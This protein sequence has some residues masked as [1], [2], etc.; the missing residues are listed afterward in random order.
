MTTITISGLP[1]TGKTTVAKLLENRLGLRYVYSGE[2]F[3]NMAKKY[4][5]SLEEFG[6]YCE[7]HREIDEDL[8]RYQLG[9]LRQGSVIVEG[10]ISG[11]LA[12]QNHIP[13]VKVLLEAD[14]AI[15]AGRIVKR[16]AGDLEKRKKEILK[17][18]KSEATRYKK[19]YG[20][21]VADTS[22]YDVI[23]DAGDKTPDE[24]MEIIVKHLGE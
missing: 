6:Q 15:R 20:I 18:E 23:I 4:K 12:A 11:W 16:E 19:Y 3:R 8:D 10:R 1:G 14:I 17:R 9:I 24:I 5:M 2:I 22:I 7:T 13:A 21:D